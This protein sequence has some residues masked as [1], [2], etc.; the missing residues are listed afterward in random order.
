M[1][2]SYGRLIIN[3]SVT[4]QFVVYQKDDV[5]VVVV[6]SKK[7]MISLTSIFLVLCP[8]MDREGILLS[9]LEKGPS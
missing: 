1:I 2:M 4:H 8:Y 7:N 9:P 3:Q 5:S 6:Q